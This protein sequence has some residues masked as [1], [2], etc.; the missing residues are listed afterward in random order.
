LHSVRWLGS[1]P[2]EQR[3]KPHQGARYPTHTDDGCKNTIQLAP[4]EC[5]HVPRSVHSQRPG[6]TNIFDF[7]SLTSIHAICILTNISSSRTRKL[8]P[9]NPN[10]SYCT[11]HN[12]KPV[13]HALNPVNPNLSYCTAHSPKPATHALNPV[14]PN[15]SYCT[16]HSPKPATHAHYTTGVFTAP[17]DQS[18]AVTTA[19]RVL[20]L[21]M[22][23]RPAIWRVAVNILNKQ[24]RKAD[25]GWSSSLWLGEEL[26][27]PRC[28][29]VSCYEIF[30]DKA[31][32]LN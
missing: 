16:A 23:E 26:T 21:R 11:A 5:Y 20:R 18:V 19:W 25:K 32:D 2:A 10:L 3:E 7:P 27:T 22:E 31:S 14:N 24:S 12:P 9:V 30:T 15:L 29:M 17:R 8:N 13:A 6:R 1:V 4:S 28:E